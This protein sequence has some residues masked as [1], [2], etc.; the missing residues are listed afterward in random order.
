LLAYNHTSLLDFVPADMSLFGNAP[1]T[2]KILDRQ[3]AA[4]SGSTCSKNVKEGAETEKHRGVVFVVVAISVGLP[5]C[6]RDWLFASRLAMSCAQE[7]KKAVG[8][9][10]E[11][12]FATI[13]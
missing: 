13:G 5:Q 4:V 6:V 8:R 3:C 9:D 11:D 2:G 12:G 10:D 7:V 1:G